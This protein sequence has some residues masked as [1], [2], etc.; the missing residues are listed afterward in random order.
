MFAVF[1]QGALLGAA[2]ILPLGPQNAFVM[3]QGI[4]RQY[5]LMVALLCALSDMVLITAGIFGGS[6]LL[7]QSSLL[8]GAVTWGGVAFLLWFGWG[9]MKTAFSKNIVLASAEVMKQSRWRII[10]TMLAVTWLNP[11]VYLDTFVV[12]GSLGSQFAGDARSWFALGTMT[13]SF[14]WFF[15]LALLA[16]WLAPWLNTPRVQRVI[17]FFVGVVMWGIALQLA[18]HGWQ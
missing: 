7:S 12:L 10:A 5:H 16:S 15:A 13:A 11:H 4:R 9:A 17:N 18:R 8:L 2:M 1:L 6:A 14:T 3:N